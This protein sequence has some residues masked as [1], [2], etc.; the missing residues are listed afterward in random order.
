MA[1]LTAGVRQNG[2]S[3]KAL[4]Q[5]RFVLHDVCAKGKD[6]PPDFFLGNFSRKFSGP[7]MNLGGNGTVWPLPRGG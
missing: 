4:P 6:S 2:R 3:A 1:Q 7:E 5:L